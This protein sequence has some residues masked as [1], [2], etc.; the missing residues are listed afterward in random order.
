MYE[1]TEKNNFIVQIVES[2]DF[3]VSLDMYLWHLFQI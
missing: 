1:I 2:F 3:N